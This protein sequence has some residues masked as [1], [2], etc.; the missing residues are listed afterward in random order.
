MKSLSCSLSIL[1]FAL[2]FTTRAFALGNG[3]DAGG[4]PLCLTDCKQ[5]PEQL[6]HYVKDHPIVTEQDEINYFF[7]RMR[8]SKNKFIRNGQEVDAADAADYLKWK[9]KRY[10]YKHKDKIVTDED[11]IYKVMK[12]SEQTGKP[13]VVVLQDGSKH[14]AQK[15]MLN[16]LNYLES[17][18]G[19]TP[20][21]PTLAPH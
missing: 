6:D 5:I 8:V 19:Q 4:V 20:E 10:E 17:F 7:Y 15:I 16:E 2:A 12:G 14:N 13:Y 11:F 21:P 1:L 18:Q 3:M 9:I